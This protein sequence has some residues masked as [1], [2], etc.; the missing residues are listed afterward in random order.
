MNNIL[1]IVCIPNNH[2]IGGEQWQVLYE[3]NIKILESIYSNA[4]LAH[5]CTTARTLSFRTAS[6]A[7][8]IWSGEMTPG[9]E[10]GDDAFKGLF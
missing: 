4:E 8:M 1:H 7:Q 6:S 2:F 3:E 10:E 5:A 9:E